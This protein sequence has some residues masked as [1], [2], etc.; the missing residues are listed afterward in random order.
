MT[1]HIILTQDSMV[2]D[3]DLIDRFLSDCQLRR[4]S[5]ETIEGYRSSLRIT[6][7]VLANQGFSIRHL[8]KTSLIEILKHLVNQGYVY[9][10]F[11]QY[12]A[13]LSGFSDY[14]IWEGIAQTNQ[15]TPFRKRYL[16][17]YKKERTVRK[18]ISVEEM[19]ALINSILDPRDKAILTVLAKT[20]IRRGELINMDLE[21]IDWS[22]QS[23][24]LK[25]H[26][27]RSN[28]TVFFDN[29][30]AVILRRWIKGRQYYGVESNCDALFVNERGSR[31]QRHGVEHAVKKHAIRLG[32]HD[33]ESKRVEDHFS[34][35]CCRHWFTTQLRRNGM[36]RELIKELRG[37]SRNEAVDIYDHI[38]RIELKRA[39]LAAMPI[40][41]IE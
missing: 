8:D 34:P 29:E 30:T 19:A 24:Q 11:L 13:A 25:P 7:R 37:D 15:V 1:E 38:D 23:I 36:R 27:K 39:Y 14:L 12:F 20:G 17:Q 10:T 28:C 31:L 16:R 41:G 6:S 3:S 5:S 4:L 21:D 26:P 22:D 40:L 35:H 32:L 33:P 2:S 18:L 9:N